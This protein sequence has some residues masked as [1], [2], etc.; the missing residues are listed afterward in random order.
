VPDRVGQLT[1]RR[2]G[3]AQR[4]LG[5]RDRLRVAVGGLLGGD[6]QPAGPPRRGRG[7]VHRRKGA[8]KGW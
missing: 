3:K 1:P 5:H 7:E 2:G 8:P 6:R 4:A